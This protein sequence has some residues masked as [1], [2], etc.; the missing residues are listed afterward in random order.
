[1]LSATRINRIAKK[2][3]VRQKDVLVMVRIAE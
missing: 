2:T 3:D 1:M